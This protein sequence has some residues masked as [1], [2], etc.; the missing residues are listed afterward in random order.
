MWII[1]LE[2]LKKNWLSIVILLVVMVFSLRTGY[3]LGKASVK[4]PEVKTGITVIDTIILH[5]TTVIKVNKFTTRDVSVEVYIK[6]SITKEIIVVKDTSHCIAMDTLINGVYLSAEMCSRFFPVNRPLDLTGTF[7]YK[8]K[9]DT[10]RVRIDTVTFHTPFF[11]E[12][13]NYIIAGLV[14]GIGTGVYFHFRK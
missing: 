2:F 1:I 4:C 6:D 9:P 10:L 14:A 5:D 7:L 8:A 12:P 11:K 13:R 3:S